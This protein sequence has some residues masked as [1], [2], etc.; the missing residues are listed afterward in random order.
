[1]INGQ[2][3]TQYKELMPMTI[4]AQ[5]TTQKALQNKDRFGKQGITN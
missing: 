3:L 2:N 4:P 1:M 5:Q